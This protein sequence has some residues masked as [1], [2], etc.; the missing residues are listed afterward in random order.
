MK[1]RDDLVSNGYGARYSGCELSWRISVDSSSAPCSAA[2]PPAK[3]RT[4]QQRYNGLVPVL[5]EPRLARN[6]R[7]LALKR[8]LLTPLS[9][10]S[11]GAHLVNGAQGEENLHHKAA[12]PDSGLTPPERH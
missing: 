7:Q 8:Q 9:V 10:S 2:L 4:I 11:E 1:S 12:D 6:R 3:T 5:R